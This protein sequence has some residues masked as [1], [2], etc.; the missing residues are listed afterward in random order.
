[1]AEQHIDKNTFLRELIHMCNVC[2]SFI[3]SDAEGNDLLNKE[4]KKFL[5]EKKFLSQNKELG[6]EVLAALKNIF[7]RSNPK[8]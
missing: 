6:L 5:V 1:M 7:A 3:F 2:D 4:I 8:K